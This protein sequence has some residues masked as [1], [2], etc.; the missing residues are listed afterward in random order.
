VESLQ[1][2][3]QEMRKFRN[4]KSARKFV[5]SLG[6]KN[7]KEWLEYC[8]SGNKPDN[9]PA[10]LDTFYKNKGWTA[11]GDFLGTG[12][13]A[14][15]DKTYRPFAEAREFT[16]ELNL[17]T[18]KEWFEYCKSGNKPKDIPGNANT[19]YKK[20]WTAWGDFLGTG[21]IATQNKVYR[22]YKDA[23]EFVQKLGLKNTKE[24]MA[25]CKSGNKPDDIP[26]TPQNTYK[27]SGWISVGDFLGTGNVASQNRTHRPFKEAREFVISLGLKNSKEWFEYCKSGNKPDDIPATPWDVYKEGNKK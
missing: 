20:E 2:M 1:G 4:F 22:S 23:R 18:Q 25:Y 14:N 12:T 24:W 3:E 21:R 8:K 10:N 7:Y 19:T 17:K 26:S 6:L 11:W 15:K 27:N 9:I 13:V 16:R 5:R